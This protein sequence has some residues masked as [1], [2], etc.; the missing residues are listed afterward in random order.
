MFALFRILGKTFYSFCE[1][2]EL[3]RVARNDDVAIAIHRESN[4]FT[5]MSHD[6]NLASAVRIG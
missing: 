4:L 5:S 1:H 6:T 3:G 2:L